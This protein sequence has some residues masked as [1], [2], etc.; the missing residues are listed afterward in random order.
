MF[1]CGY[2]RGPINQETTCDECGRSDS[3]HVV[4][5]LR[6]YTLV[7]LRGEGNFGKVYRCQRHDG[8]DVA[9][10]LIDLR[11]AARG[12]IGLDDKRRS[13][14]NEVDALARLQNPRVVG[15]ETHGEC[16]ELLFVVM[17][18][19]PRTLRQVLDRSEPIPLGR[20]VDLGVELADALV[21]LHDHGILHRDI[22]PAN[23]GLDGEGHV[24]LLD[25]GIAALRG[26]GFDARTGT[27][28]GLGSPQYAAPEQLLHAE[29]SA[30]SDIYSFGAVLYEIIA[31]HAHLPDP[32][33]R[34][35]VLREIQAYY[36]QPL[37]SLPADPSR[38][39]IVDFL[40]HRC[41]EPEPAR[42]LTQMHA[43]QALIIDA[44]SWLRTEA[45]HRSLTDEVETLE[46]RRGRLTGDI[47][48]LERHHRGLKEKVQVLGGELEG[49]AR[50]RV[51]LTAELSRLREESAQVE[52]ILAS[53]QSSLTDEIETLERRHRGL[54]EKVQVLGGELEGQARQRVALTAELSRLREEIAQVE[55]NLTFR[56]SQH[57]NGPEAIPI[58]RESARVEPSDSA[59][60]SWRKRMGLAQRDAP[61]P[62]RSAVRLEPAASE[63]SP[64]RR[65]VRAPKT[66]SEPLPA[67]K[68]RPALVRIP[69]GLFQM[70]SPDG[71]G[72]DNEHP[73]HW[74][75]I[76]RSMWF[77]ETAVTQGQFQALMGKNPSYF[78]GAQAN[79]HDRPVEL[80][81]WY[82][83][84]VFCNK[85]S[86]QEGLDPCYVLSGSRGDPA[87]GCSKGEKW[88][89]GDH[90]IKKVQ[91]KGLDCNGY[92]LPA[93]AEWEYACRGGTET[94][95]WSG[96]TEQDLA[97]VGWYD[98]NSGFS[99][100]PVGQKREPR[101]PWGLM[102][103]HGN[104]WEWCHDGLRSYA[105]TTKGRPAVD[106]IGP[107][108]GDWRVIRG[109]S[110]WN[111]ADWAR[112]ACRNGWYPLNRVQ[113]LGFR[114]VRPVVPEPG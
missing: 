70:G 86:T 22:K 36:D 73:R 91:L 46:R 64:E 4:D 26:A 62:K 99:T 27:L 15:Y 95:Y 8:G 60:P 114:V 32:P 2:C 42:R 105:S 55:A 5:G 25:F 39:P 113:N 98:S 78:Q 31:G 57:V 65:P 13:F 17:D 94:R 59:Q 92:R 38:P 71:E 75:H 101:H 109:G 97:R 104:V 12:G 68:S 102:D 77:A 45:R 61:A 50:Q 72:D 20:A 96:D 24:R 7:T 80:V 79:G 112:S 47:E 53:R 43:V 100:H 44:R 89:E 35:R 19:V 81:S 48:D 49:Q 56:R 108:G 84:L 88:C 51:A 11:K 21:H 74:V 30:G 3:V 29:G 18:F 40:L 87:G 110:F 85:L 6:P 83:A 58:A 66:S 103:M 111:V 76:S 23:V 63:A 41:L 107:P 106:P 1:I 10:K 37:R 28:A 90:I 52:A 54:K 14:R 93:E 67:T 82:D 16:I 34:P 69:A 9:L 33:T